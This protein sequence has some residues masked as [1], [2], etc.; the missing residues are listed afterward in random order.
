MDIYF[1]S[2]KTKYKSPFG[3]G[4]TGTVYRFMIYSSEECEISLRVFGK[5]AGDSVIPMERKEGGYYTASYTA[6]AKPG[7]VFYYFIL[8]FPGG[9]AYY[10]GNCEDGLGG[11]GCIYAEDPVPYQ[12]TV[13]EESGV[14]AWYKNAVVY[15]IFPDRFANES[16]EEEGYPEEWY[17]LP[18]YERDEEGAIIWKFYGGTLKGVEEKLPYLKSLGVSCIYF[19]PIFKA[20]TNHRYDTYDYFV[21]DER[22]G[23]D[24][25]FDSFIASAKRFGIRI[26]LD[27]VFNH[28]GR[29]SRY[30]EEHPDWYSGEYWWGVRD[31][32]EF[33]DQNREYRDFICGENGVVRYWIRRGISGWR[34]DVVDE[35]PDDFVKEIRAA[36]KAEDPEAVIIGEV[37]EDASNKFSHGEHREYFFGKELDGV[38]NYP[39]RELFLDFA[40]FGCTAQEAEK[41]LMS[42]YEN[43]PPENIRA[44]FNLIDS[45]D[46]ERALSLLGGEDHSWYALRRLK[47]GLAL[48]YAAPGVPTVYYGD[49]AGM[50]GGRDPENRGAYP[51]GRENAELLDWYRLLGQIYKDHPVMADGDM[52]PLDFGSEV[53]GLA[54]ENGK[55]RMLV[56]LNRNDAPMHIEYGFGGKYALE[57]TRSEELAVED[58]VLKADIEGLSASLV[59]L[60][61]EAPETLKLQRG[62]G[63]LCHITSIPG[64][65]LGRPAKDFVDFIASADFKYWQV[66]PINPVGMGDSPYMSPDV[67]GIEEKLGTFE[68]LKELREYANSKGIKLIGDLPIYVAPE[69]EDVRRDPAAFQTGRHAGCPPDYFTPLGQDWGNP[70]YDWD[71]IKSTGY[72]WWIRR[73]RKALEYFDYVRIDH[74]RGFAAYFSIPNEGSP[75]DGYWMPGPGTAMFRAVKEALSEDGEP[76]PVIA[77]DLGFLDAQVYNLMKLTGFPGL[78]V[79]QTDREVMEKQTAAA[80]RHRVYYPGTHDSDT[81]VGWLMEDGKMDLCGARGEADRIIEKLY[82]SEAGWVIVTLQDMLGLDSSARMNVP[83]TAEG[84]WQWKADP[85]SLTPELAAKYRKLAEKY[86][87]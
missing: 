34:L 27:G 52:K 67:F 2:H 47:M 61:A 60:M 82:A 1:S 31:L 41:R 49:E 11:E 8:S 37:W 85:A 40:M 73:I 80:R 5:E 46:R 42:L 38:M 55:E 48:Q 78:N 17:E 10:Y 45:H 58:G 69:G 19:N 50:Y 62:A 68:Q 70:L 86:C 54:L 56:L 13:Y 3:A 15:Q 81:L 36:A 87:R 22:F 65:T 30:I 74:F 79:Y 9:S 6:P 53:L 35:L 16:F 21:I 25:D 23:T 4:K 18:S 24:A 26:I 66:L 84:N 29:D 64:G 57:L 44:S 39:F 72:E 77:E 59:L 28:S 83:G 51:W 76:L 7:L 63:I 71:Y 43:Y 20:R 75:K 12:I 32:P 14:P 33:D